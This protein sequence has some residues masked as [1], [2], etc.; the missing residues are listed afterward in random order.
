MRNAYRILLRKPKGEKVLGG[1]TSKWEDSIT[2]DLK[3]NGM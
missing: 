2:V 1:A 3:I